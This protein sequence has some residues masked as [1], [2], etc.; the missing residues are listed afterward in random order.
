MTDKI[1]EDAMVFNYILNPTLLVHI[2]LNY[3]F[4]AHKVIILGIQE[5][6]K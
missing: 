5:N 6:G 4:A 3:Y 1:L 2:I